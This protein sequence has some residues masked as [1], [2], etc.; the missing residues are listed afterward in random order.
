MADLMDVISKLY[1]NPLQF[2]NPRLSQFNCEISMY[3]DIQIAAAPTLDANFKG[4]PQKGQQVYNHEK[5]VFYSLTP[6]ECTEIVNNLKKIKTGTYED[7][8]AQ[9]ER[10]KDVFTIT[11]FKENEPSHLSIRTL[12]NPQNGELLNG[13][14][15]TITPVKSSGFESVSH[16]FTGTQLQILGHFLKCGSEFLPFMN[17]FFR[18]LIKLLKY[19]SFNMQDNSQNNQGY[20]Q[21]PKQQPPQ[22]TGGFVDESNQQNDSDLDDLFGQSTNASAVDDLDFGSSRTQVQEEDDSPF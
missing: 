8:K 21:K 14:K 2:N 20:Q 5:K 1:N 19:T 18:S 15:I 22:K 9:N 11:H 10:Y 13:V 17:Q 6:A 3:G 12:K 4:R 7:P 16:N